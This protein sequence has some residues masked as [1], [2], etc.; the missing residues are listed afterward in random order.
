VDQFIGAQA[1]CLF[2]LRV[3]WQRLPEREDNREKI[4]FGDVLLQVCAGGIPIGA[5]PTDGLPI[6]DLGYES[7]FRDASGRSYICDHKPTTLTYRYHDCARM[8]RWET[9]WVGETT[10]Q[11]THPL[12]LSK[13][14]GGSINQINRIRVNWASSQGTAPLSL[15]LQSVVASPV[16]QPRPVG[17]TR[18]ELTVFATNGNLA[19]LVFLA[20]R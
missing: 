6:S 5:R 15:A 20:S 7:N 14:T 2:R 17:I 19:R 18:L 1:N 4:V 10:G 16:P 3:C 9:R 8:G 12:S 13:D 11:A